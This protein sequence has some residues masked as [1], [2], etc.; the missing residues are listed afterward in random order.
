MTRPQ[1][2]LDRTNLALADQTSDPAVVDVTNFIQP[3]FDTR[4]FQDRLVTLGLT[5]V[6]VATEILSIV[7]GPVPRNEIW[8]YTEISLRT[9]SVAEEWH[10]AIRYQLSGDATLRDIHIQNILI[11]ANVVHPGSF[12]R[13]LES[14]GAAAGG[15]SSDRNLVLWPGQSMLIESNTD[16][17]ITQTIRLDLNY[18]ISKSP[19][20]RFVTNDNAANLAVSEI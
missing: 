14:L 9:G 15:Y 17:G 1:E 2:L 7:H 20:E 11:G 4:V 18:R 16:V 19:Q 12:L 6:M 3:V 5:H 10:Q 13:N 8:T